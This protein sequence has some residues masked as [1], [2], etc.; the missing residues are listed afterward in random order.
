M[1]YVGVYKAVYAYSP[2]TEEELAIE[3]GDILY[4]IEKSNT[5][6]W[7]KVKKRMV[8]SDVEEPSGLV[9]STY[10]EPAATIGSASALYDYT[11]QTE[12][13]LSF[14]EGDHFHV[15]DTSDGDWILVSDDAESSFGFVPANYIEVSTGEN[16]AP[17]NANKSLPAQPVINTNNA[18]SQMSSFAP[19]PAR[20]DRQ[21]MADKLSREASESEERE[22]AKSRQSI[23]RHS[24]NSSYGDDDYESA[25]ELPPDKPKRPS[26]ANRS[27]SLHNKRGDR[28]RVTNDSV[29]RIDDDDDLDRNR[30]RNQNGN[31]DIY[32][33]N[34]AEVEGKKKKKLTIGIGNGKIYFSPDPSNDDEPRSWSADKLISFSSE[35]K[36]VFLD[37]KGPPAS[38]EIHAGSKDKAREIL[39]LLG[40]VSGAISTAALEE[41]KAASKPTANGYKTGSVLYDFKAQNKDELNAKDGDLVYIVNDKK[42]PDWWLV[43]NIDT[44]KRGVIPSTYVNVG[45]ENKRFTLGD[46]GKKTKDS[47]KSKKTKA[48]E[49]QESRDREH[50]RERERREREKERERREREKER[51]KERNRERE[52][53]ERDREHDREYEGRDRERRKKESKSTKSKAKPNPNKIR[54]WVD[55]SGSFKVEAEFIGCVEGKIHLHK[56]NGVKI[57][58][59]ADK[60]ALPDI[61]YVERVTGFS[62]DNYKPKKKEKSSRSKEKE[63]K[64]SSSNI[65]STKQE[66]YDWFD[67]F[68]NCGVDLNQCQRY[69]T[70][71]EKEQLDES[72]LED[73]TPSLLRNLGCREGD[74]I[75][76]MKFLDNKFNRSKPEV[77]SAPAAAAAT[78][79]PETAPRPQP[80]RIDS[81]N[82]NGVTDDDAWT[83]KP[84]VAQT[85]NKPKS[86]S[87]P[88]PTTTSQPQITGSL[89]DLVDL[90]PLDSNYVASADPLKNNTAVPAIAPTKTGSSI[91]LGQQKTGSSLVNQLLSQKTGSSIKSQ[92]TGSLQPLDPF[93]TG[94]HNILPMAT[95]APIVMPNATGGASVFV[96]IQTMQPVLVGQPTANFNPGNGASIMPLQPARTNNGP[97]VSVTT[98][99]AMPQTSFG[100]V[101]SITTS[102]GVVSVTTGGAM[103]QTSFGSFQPQQVTGGVMP[104]M[105]TGGAIPMMQTGGAMP[106]V[107]TGGAMPMMQ[108][109]GAM[110]MTSFGTFQPQQQ[111]VTGGIMPMQMTSN[112]FQPQQMTGGAMPTTSF[113]SSPFGQPQQQQQFPQ[114]SF[115]NQMNSMTNM[116]Q[117]TSLTGQQ[118]Q[119]QPSGVAS[120]NMLHNMQAQ[121]QHQQQLQQA[122]MTGAQLFQNQ[123]APSQTGFGGPQTSFGQ[124]L[125]SFG[126]PTTTSFGA[127]PPTSFGVGGVQTASQ[128][129]FTNSL[130]GNEVNNGSSTGNNNIFG[131][132]GQMLTSQPTGFGFGNG[133]N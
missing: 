101:T 25:G 45:G 8:G 36:H 103:P 68:L 61:E 129:A 114:T 69:T 63:R 62:L 126:Q 19:P 15:Y 99:G 49:L 55:K 92:R 107:Q 130:M 34:V 83:I 121:Q 57:A 58:V 118:Q 44:G 80:P 79:P 106:M 12:E 102:N 26:N 47:M 87:A 127:Q 75:R 39:S 116:F 111:Q 41:V 71:F 28:Q 95:G 32:T 18:V 30:D 70:N 133:P 37:F 97:V 52:R 64:P 72:S 78:V 60:L 93:K 17:S 124:P 21:A 54:T 43:E 3:E 105:Q 20:Y 67:F 27:S 48:R 123:F 122:Q 16:S 56:S 1:S 115:G 7:W 74:I 112:G 100:T 33:W 109:G 88:P 65:P 35:K 86:I 96:P 90:K 113:G 46:I 104:M 51:E 98:G 23:S 4:V 84:S 31:S 13:E 9:P 10:I 11:K 50:E 89:Q 73:V 108:T 77:A 131:N 66:E 117:N 22:H 125:T 5:D 85:E 42:S 81:K 128:Q 76:I 2:A 40:E 94:G 38:I 59:A 132:N 53:R 91:Q 14:H 24:R 110:P 29:P 6:D 119:Q 120:L 82:L